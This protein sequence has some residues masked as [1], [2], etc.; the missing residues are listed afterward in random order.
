MFMAV[1]GVVMVG[2]WFL[3]RQSRDR[4]DSAPFVLAALP[5]AL[6]FLIAP[7]PLTAVQTVR[8]FQSIGA[9]KDGV[10]VALGMAQPLW[11]GGVGFL[12]AIGVAAGLQIAARL[13]LRSEDSSPDPDAARPTWGKWILLASSLLVVPVGVLTHL[14]RGIA[15]LIM[16]AVVPTPS[17]GAAAGVDVARISALITSRLLIAALGG[18]PLL[19]IVL[20]FGVANLFTRINETSE[21]L[22]RFSWTVFAMVVVAGVWNVVAL[23]ITDPLD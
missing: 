4:H 3:L 5:L 13:R 22:E 15:T 14:T 7:V 18:F 16:Q 6:L 23:S 2:F 11:L 1:A 9:R 12:V 21:A 10:R 17:A 19:F 8:A 20:V